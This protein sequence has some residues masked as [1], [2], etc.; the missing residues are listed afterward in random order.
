MMRSAMVGFLVY[1]LGTSPLFAAE[2]QI[3]FLKAGA[4]LRL[5]FIPRTIKSTGDR[6]WIFTGKLTLHGESRTIQVA[7]SKL[8]RA[9][10]GQ[11]TIRQTGFGIRPVSVAGGTVTVKNELTI[12]FTVVT[13][14]PPTKRRERYGL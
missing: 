13:K 6:H 10:V 8:E 1:C 5:H 7:V 9:Y 11:T 2:M 3:E 12:G 4:F 14:R